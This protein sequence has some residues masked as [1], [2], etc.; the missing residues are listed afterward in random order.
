MNE[1][2]IQQAVEEDLGIKVLKSLTW[3][4]QAERRCEEAVRSLFLIKRNVSWKTSEISKACTKATSFLL[5][6][7]EQFSGKVQ[8]LRP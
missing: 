3:K 1:L 8:R 5:Y 2:T 6:P 7:T 4:E